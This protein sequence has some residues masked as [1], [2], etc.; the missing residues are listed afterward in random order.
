[1]SGVAKLRVPLFPAGLRLL[2]CSGAVNLRG[3]LV[4]IRR[5]AQRSHAGAVGRGM[6]LRAVSVVFSR[7]FANMLNVCARRDETNRYSEL[8]SSSLKQCRV[9]KYAIHLTECASA[10]LVTHEGSL[11]QARMFER[12]CKLT[13]DCLQMPGLSREV[14]SKY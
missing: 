6:R 9:G 1:M 7:R 2:G 10:A 8:R 5:G 12:F 4:A 14:P 3:N 11:R 13:R